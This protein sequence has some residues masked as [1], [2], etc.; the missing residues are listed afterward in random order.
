[1][2]LYVQ[3]Q[4]PQAHALGYALPRQF[5]PDI[6]HD[7]VPVFKQRANPGPA[8]GQKRLNAGRTETLDGLPDGAVAHGGVETVEAVRLLQ[9][10]AV[11]AGSQIGLAHAPPTEGASPC[12]QESWRRDRQCSRRQVQRRR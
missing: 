1:M 5:S 8:L 10:H 9:A 4:P 6:D 3:L 7:P 12:L 11:P 2:L